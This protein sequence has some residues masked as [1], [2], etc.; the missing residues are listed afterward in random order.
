[1]NIAAN[2]L[3]TGITTDQTANIITNNDKLGYT[4]ALVSAN[5]VVVANKA[6]IAS[7]TMRVNNL[8]AQMA[9]F[10]AQIN[11]LINEDEAPV[12]SVTIDDQVWQSANLDVT[13]YRDG[14]V[15][16]EVTDPAAWEN[17]K[18]GAWCYYDNEASNSATYG[19]LYNWYAVMGITVAEA[20]TLTEAQIAA[21]KKLA[22]TGWHV[23]SDG[24][25]EYINHFFRSRRACG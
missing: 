12:P 21:R 9:D 4:E 5:A 19:K 8:A 18:T 7:E 17:L 23:P 6:T 14:T 16:P 2:T 20:A 22:A 10:Q 1:V 3:K 15:I 25:M 24:G 13:T 11:A